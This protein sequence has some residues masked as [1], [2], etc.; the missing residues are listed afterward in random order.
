MP[1][2]FLP[3]KPKKHYFYAKNERNAE[4]QKIYN[5]KNYKKLRNFYLQNNPL[6][7]MCLKLG[8]FV[9]G[10][11]VDH[12]KEIS[13]GITL[14]DKLALALDYKNLQTLCLE[15]HHKKHLKIILYL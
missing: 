1:T 10:A 5:S 2:I 7:A 4:I 13:S 8:L 6:C 11:E 3:K 9:S 15:C 14:A 12:I